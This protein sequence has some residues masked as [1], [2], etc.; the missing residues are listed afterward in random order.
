MSIQTFHATLFAEGEQSDLFGYL[1]NV[2]Q[3]SLKD[4][5]AVRSELAWDGWG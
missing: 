5:L 3:A 2:A 4:V 1:L